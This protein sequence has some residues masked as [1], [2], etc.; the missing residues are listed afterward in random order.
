MKKQRIVVKIGS[1]SLTNPGGELSREKLKSYTDA[2]AALRNEGHQVILISSG[3]VAAG[4][5]GLN[6]PTRP[7]TLAGKQAAAAVGQGLLMQA[8]TEAFN[9]YKIETGQILLTRSNFSNKSQYQNAYSTLSELLHRGVLPIIN[10]NDTIA[11]DELTFGDNDMLSALVGGLIH[12]DCLIILTDINGIYDSNP[13]TNPQA[14]RYHFLSEITPDLYEQAGDAGSNVGTGGMK[15]KLEA[16]ETALSLGLR[17]FI[18]T[19][20]GSAFLSDILAGKGDGTYIGFPGSFVLNSKKQWLALHSLPAGGLTI[21]NGAKTALLDKGKS[22]LPAGII[23][24]QGNFESGAVVEVKDQKGQIIG[25][26]QV[27][28]SANEIKEIK[29]KSSYDA[30]LLTVTN[31]AEVIHRDEWVHLPKERI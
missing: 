6:Y 21:D 10:E 5:S 11:V 3:A 15:S 26:G 30:S 2:I 23:N 17:T 7:V 29:G 16:A 12:A 24:V 9:E 19:G 31:K 1:S 20:F 14:K 22:L 25:K 13:N 8:Y 18:G 28:M 4:F 27:N